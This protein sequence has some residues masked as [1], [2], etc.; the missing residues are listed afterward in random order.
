MVTL[1]AGPADG[2]VRSLPP[3][4]YLAD[5]AGAEFIDWFARCS[6]AAR[7][8]VTRT[9][10][11]GLRRWRFDPDT[12]N[13]AHDSG[14]FFVVEG[15]E[16]R[17]GYGPVRA[18]SQPI[19]NQPEIGILGMLVKEVDGVPYCLVQAKIE[20]GNHNGIQVSPTVQATRSNYTRIHQGRSTRYLEYFTDPGAGRTLV[21]VLQ[22]EQGSW[23]LRKRNRN[24]VVQV[25]EDVPAGEDHHWLPLPELRRLLRIDGLVNMDTRTVLACL[26]ADTFPAS[27]PVPAGDAASALVLSTTGRGPALNDTAA[28]LRW[29]TGAKSR[30]ELSAHRIP[31]RAL[32]GWRATPEA[33][34]HEDGRHFSII[35]VTAQVGNREVAEWDQPL[36]YPEGRGVV[37]FVIKVIEG[38]A[39]LLVH[40]RFQPGLLDGMEMGPTVQCVPENYPDGPPRFLDYVLNAPRER[41][42]YNAVLAEEGG[43]FYHSQNNYLLVEAGDDFPTAVPEDYCW[44]TAHQLTLLLRHGYYVNVEARSLLACLQSW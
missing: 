43:R 14:A 41:V 3:E 23:F 4:A 24:M 15:L 18:W 11:D 25:T 6:A 13:L 2:L 35:G 38:V 9:P 5:F 36:L 16:V 17:T 21:D 19:I 29:F 37:A 1:P 8:R 12:G 42:L 44:M 10:L 30:H 33:I 7:C 39:H 40:A 20:P 26:P 32:P 22:S 28:V 34:A 27:Q 31:L